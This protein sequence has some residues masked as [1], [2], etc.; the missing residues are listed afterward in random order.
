M[1]RLFLYQVKTGPGKVL[2]RVVVP[3]GP[4]GRKNVHFKHKKTAEVFYRACRREIKASGRDK[5]VDF[6]VSAHKLN[7]ALEARRLLR[8]KDKEPWQN[9]LRRA[10][11]LLALSEGYG[12]GPYV[13]PDSRSLELSPPLLKAVNS[14]AR[15]KG[16]ALNDLLT[17]LLWEYVRRE[18][19]ALVSGKGEAN[20]PKRDLYK[21]AA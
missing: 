20:V 1:A 9:R 6:L 14:L 3:A 12:L 5:A 18:S 11:A 13:E 4:T 7:D 21:K 10:A 16:V 8:D 2:W 19:E 17:G 15:L